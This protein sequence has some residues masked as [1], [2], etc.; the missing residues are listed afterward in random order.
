[1][2]QNKLTFDTENLVVYWLEI[3]IEGLYNLEGIHALDNYFYKKLELNSTFQESS[4]R[5][6]QSLISR[7]ANQFNVLFVKTWLKYWSRTKLIF[8]NE[9]VADFY[10][11]VQEKKVDWKILKLGSLS[12]SRFDFYYFEKI[13]DSAKSSVK[14]FL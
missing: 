3:S 7:P 2:K 13:N 12:L 5:N 1:M 11:L 10:K 9:N 4:K 6:S 14:Y 8:S